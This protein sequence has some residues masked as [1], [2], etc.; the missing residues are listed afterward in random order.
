MVFKQEISTFEKVLFKRDIVETYIPIK[1]KAD[2]I[3][4]VFELYSDITDL[5]EELRT[6]SWSLVVFLFLGN[7][8]SLRSSS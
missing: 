3:V 7:G 4:A 8:Y 5:V 6:D 2:N 1:N